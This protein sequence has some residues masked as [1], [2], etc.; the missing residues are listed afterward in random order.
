MNAT[1]SLR[2]WPARW[3]QSAVLRPCMEGREFL[4]T[5]F[6]LEAGG[7]VYVAATDTRLLIAAAVPDTD[8][9]P[10]PDDKAGVVMKALAVPVEWAT[11]DTDTLREFVGPS[12]TPHYCECGFCGRKRKAPTLPYGKREGWIGSARLDLLYAAELL[13][14]VPDEV[15]EIGTA[16]IPGHGAAHRLHARGDGWRAMLMGLVIF[17]TE[18]YEAEPRFPLP[19]E[20]PA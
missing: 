17:E 12:E 20:A 16:P 8:L 2:E 9:A 14:G 1:E 3:L 6:R 7:R 4:H 15:V 13:D 19:I 11:V 10:L 5:P 18:N